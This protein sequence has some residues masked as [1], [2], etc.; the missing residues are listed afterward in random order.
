MTFDEWAA[1]RVM[2]SMERE[3]ARDAWATATKT[4]RDATLD[5]VL[6][7]LRS[8]NDSVQLRAIITSV[9]AMRSNG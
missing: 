6:A 9:E 7:G 2:G 5:K 1:G 3:F 4:E 8:E